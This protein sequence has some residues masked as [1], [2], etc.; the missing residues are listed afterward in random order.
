VLKDIVSPP[1]SASLNVEILF[2]D[3][4]PAVDLR[5]TIQSAD[6]TPLVKQTDANGKCKYD[7][8]DPDRYKVTVQVPAG[9]KAVSM[10][11]DVDTGVGARLL[12]KMEAV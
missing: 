5:V 4:T 2:P 12:I 1:G 10:N 9:F 6:G 3:N 11:K 8:I 7:S